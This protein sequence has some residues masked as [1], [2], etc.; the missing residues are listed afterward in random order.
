MPV[1][2]G[3]VQRDDAA[4]HLHVVDA[5]ALHVV[6]EHKIAVVR[7]DVVAQHGH[8]GRGSRAQ[9]HRVIAGVDSRIRAA[10]EHADA[11]LRLGA[12]ARPV[13]HRVAEGV[14]AHGIGECLV[15][16]IIRSGFHHAAEFGR[17]VAQAEQ[18]HVIAV[19]VDAGHANRDADLSASSHLRL[20]IGG[21]RRGFRFRVTVM[22]G[23]GDD[24]R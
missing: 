11:N 19:R 18:L 8:G 3:V 9:R 20:D 21:F 4:L 22:H 13:L 5:L 2:S 7:R 10:L 15:H 24:G 14:G 6:L 1:W 23:E 12:P 16:Q 17:I